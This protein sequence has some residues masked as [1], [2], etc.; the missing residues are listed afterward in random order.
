MK[1][2]AAEFEKSV[3]H[4]KD[5]PKDPLAEVAF[6][7]R[8]NVGKSSMMNTL[9]GRKGLV[10]TSSTPSIALNP[11]ICRA[12]VLAPAPIRP[13]RIVSSAIGASSVISGLPSRL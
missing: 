3:V 9:M 12:V 11:G 4:G 8:S 5:C 13:M 10:K 1:V 6:A 7:G 2:I